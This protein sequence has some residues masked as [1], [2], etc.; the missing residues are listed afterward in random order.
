MKR[1]LLN[2]RL[3]S[4]STTVFAL[5]AM[6]FMFQACT[7][8]QSNSSDN[9]DE[10]EVKIDTKNEDVKEFLE[11]ELNTSTEDEHSNYS[12]EQ[13]KEVRA[14]QEKRSKILNEEL[15]ASSFKDASDEEIIAYFNKELAL[16][17]NTCDTS[18]F[19][20]IRRVMNRDARIKVFSASQIDFSQDFR[21]RIK[22]AMQKCK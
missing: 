16:Y 13:K 18:V 19:N 7:S 15:N 21:A 4:T 20:S 22:E 9:D 14:S 6:C 10:V 5:F 12:D 2:I 8:C 1:I 11:K 17:Q 3:T